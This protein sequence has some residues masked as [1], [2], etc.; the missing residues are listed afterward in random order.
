MPSIRK[1]ARGAVISGWGTALPDRVVT[2]DELAAS[3]DTTDEWIRTRTGIRERRFGG[4]TIGLSVQAGRQAI[5][6]AGL[7]P[8][9]IDG[10]VLATTDKRWSH[11]AAAAAVLL[12]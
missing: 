4:T 10:V 6:M 3:L 2:N 11:N 8:S 9:R 1:G 7:D 5:E 12:L